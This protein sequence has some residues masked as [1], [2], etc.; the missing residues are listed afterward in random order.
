MPQVRVGQISIHY[1]VQGEGE[2]L[3]LITSMGSDVNAWRLQ[4]PVFS[5]KYRV[6]T[7]DNRG[8][9]QSDA[10]DMPY[11]IAVM[12]DDAV[13]LMD[14]LGIEKA[15]VLGKSMGGYIA[16][17]VAMRHPGRTRSLIL[18]STSAGPHVA[19]TPVLR[20]WAEAAMKGLSKRRFFQV[21]LPFIFS[22]YTFEDP[23]M[24]DMAIEMIGGRAIPRQGDAES[25][26]SRALRRQFIACVEHFA[27]GRLNAVT[28]PTLVVAGRDEFFIPL[29]LCRELAASIRN[30]RLA[31]LESG[32]HALNEDIPKEFNRTVLSFLAEVG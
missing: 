31:I 16:Q 10:P 27:R 11:T 28:A 24:V 32:G 13:G 15:H 1:E 9:G 2:P 12:A 26:Q 5:E 17:E 18:V 21:M 14:V 20:A 30:A 8:A 6:I 25:P 4:T 22:D 3:L 23:E 7:F 29:E 19:E